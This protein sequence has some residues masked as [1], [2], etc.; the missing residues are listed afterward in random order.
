MKMAPTLLSIELVQRARTQAWIWLIEIRPLF[1]L[2]SVGLALLGTSIAWWDG[3]FSLRLAA[4]AFVALLLWH[5]SVQVLNDY[6]DY[7]SGIDLKTQRT[8]FSGGSGV[9]PA[10][11]LRPKSVFKF[12]LLTFALAVPIWIY[13][14]IEKGVLLLPVLAVG[15]VCVLLYNPVLTKWRVAEIVS[16]L[17]M[18]VLP[19]LMFY[20]VQTGS[21]NKVV[22]VGAI[23]SGILLFNLH[24]LNQFPDVEADK[25]G[26]RKTLPIVLGR[27]KAS[28]VYLAGT[29]ALYIWVSSWVAAGT[30]PL[31]ALLSLLTVP[32]A[33]RVIK[34]A[35]NYQPVANFTPVL[36]AGAIAYFLTLLLLAL[37][38]IVNSL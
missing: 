8:L 3:F 2:G 36:W 20:F 4:L 18:G 15:A 13:F 28:W 29:V 12:G 26:G 19:I 22:V 37:G 10:Q 30:M 34:E 17:G 11:L 25:V 35:M 21:Y 1:L 5:I 9:L 32:A 14:L 24:L 7:R 31:A 16:G 38:Y 27:R 23:A 6:F 33:L